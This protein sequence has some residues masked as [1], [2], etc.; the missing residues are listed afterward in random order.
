MLKASTVEDLPDLPDPLD[1][2][3]AR[4]DP[5]DIPLEFEN[6]NAVGSELML[7]DGLAGALG[8]EPSEPVYALT[9]SGATS[10]FVNERLANALKTNKIAGTKWVKLPNRE[11]MTASYRISLTLQIGTYLCALTAWVLPDLDYDIILG[12]S[13]FAKFNPDI[14]WITARIKI[15]DQ[16]GKVHHLLLSEMKRATLDSGAAELNV[17]T[18]HQ[19]ARTIRKPN[20]ECLLYILKEREEKANKTSDENSKLRRLLE[21]YKDVFRADLPPG[22]PPERPFKHDIDTGDADPI[23]VWPYPLSQAHLEEQKRQITGLLERGLVRTS[24]SPW[25]FPVLFV[26]KQGG[27]WRMC[28]DYREL[29]KVTKKNK[30]PLPRIQ[31]L[32]D[33][34]GKAKVLS[35][36]DLAAGF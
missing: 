33:A 31:D 11:Y 15:R 1:L 29:N 6:L 23:N 21:K 34:I 17:I 2:S 35:K 9:D 13:W 22:L 3:E 5:K 4:I 24:S 18:A 28:V 30:Y 10:I 12:R 32:L 27:T 14:C 8:V 20:S 26:K 25:G 7:Y 36:I 16:K 19:A